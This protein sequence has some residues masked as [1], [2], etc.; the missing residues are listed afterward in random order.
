[1]GHSKEKRKGRRE[2]VFKPQCWCQDVTVHQDLEKEGFG[3]E[4]LLKE[5]Q[6][7][8]SKHTVSNQQLLSP[9]ALFCLLCYM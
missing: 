9:W 6:H 4:D 5:S 3:Q 1:M 8:Y 7:I 2:K